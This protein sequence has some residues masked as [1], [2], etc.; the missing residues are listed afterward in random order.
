MSNENK[1]EYITDE[2]I[3]KQAHAVT[4]KLS[5]HKMLAYKHLQVIWQIRD[6]L[7]ENRRLTKS[8]LDFLENC[9]LLDKENSSFFIKEYKP[10]YRNTSFE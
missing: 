3:V 4:E 7:L 6:E 8:Q 9:V 1:T 5:E 10:G 2:K